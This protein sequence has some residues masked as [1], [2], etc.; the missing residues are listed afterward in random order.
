MLSS[1][2]DASNDIKTQLVTYMNPQH[3]A[4]SE[5]ERVDIASVWTEYSLKKKEKALIEFHIL[6]QLQTG[7]QHKQLRSHLI[8]SMMVLIIDHFFID[9]TWVHH[10]RGKRRASFPTG[11]ADP[12]VGTF[13]GPQVHHSSGKFGKPS[14]PV[15]RWTLGLG[16]SCPEHQ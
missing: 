3:R 9:I 10:S 6:P 15:E 11:T 1:H 4:T 12:R 16:F 2:N 7:K 14:F 13:L 5:K 8:E